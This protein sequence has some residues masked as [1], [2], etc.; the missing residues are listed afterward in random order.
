MFDICL[1]PSDQLGPDGQR[2]GRITISDFTERFAC[3]PAIA[4]VDEYPRIWKERLR[5]LIGGELSVPLIHDPHF[6]WIIYRDGQRCHVQQRLALDGRFEPIPPRE[7]I[8]EDGDRISEWH[9]SL[10][11]VARFVAA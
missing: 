4:S 6:A 5:L 1:L 11:S 7:V 8:S 2:L 10:E 9:T 3:H